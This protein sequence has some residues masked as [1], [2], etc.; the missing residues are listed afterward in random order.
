MAWRSRVPP[1]RRGSRSP[2]RRR[3]PA[4]SRSSRRCARRSPAT[5]C[6]A[7][8]GILNGTCNYILSP[9]GARRGLT[10][11]ECL[12]D[13]QRLGYAEADPTF[14]VEGFDTAH[15]LA[16]LTSLAFGTEIDA[17]AD[18]CRGHLLDHARSTSRWRRSSASASSSSA[19]PSAPRPASSSACIRP[20]CR[21]PPPSP[22]VMGVTNAVTIDADAV[23]R[24]DADR[25][26]RRR[27]RDR[28]RRR[29]RH[30]RR[31]DRHGALPFGRPVGSAREGRSAR[32][33]S[34]TRA[35]I[36]CA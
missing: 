36:M 9:H 7:L 32:R 30:R 8:Y 5:R 10:F 11:A 2:S 27:R 16:I 20:W 31:R 35:A 1:R 15:K 34:A 12:A 26:R 22:Q 28:L 23:Q 24:A 25:P 33:C 18:L 19:S 29:R 4:A 17:E 14:D 3:S 21:E 6:R 13:A